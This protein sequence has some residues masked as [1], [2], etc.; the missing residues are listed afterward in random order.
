MELHRRE[1][2][3][4]KKGFAEFLKFDPIN[5]QK[6]WYSPALNILAHIPCWS[7]GI[8]EACIKNCRVSQEECFWIYKHLQLQ[9]IEQ[10][11]L[12]TQL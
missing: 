2:W 4:H 5:A 8:C 10:L 9:N 11:L 1:D 7:Q 12:T 6:R 3:M